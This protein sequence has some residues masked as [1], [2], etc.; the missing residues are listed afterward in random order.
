MRALS[1][2]LLPLV[3]ACGAQDGLGNTAAPAGAAANGAAPTDVPAP[4]QAVQTASL[5]GLYESGPAAR[6]SQMCII[7]RGTGNARFGLVL[8]GAGDHSCSGDGTA[9]R[10]GDRLRLT[11]SGD[12]ACVIE[13]R[14]EGGQVTLPPT[15]PASC[16]YYCGQGAR[17]AA[18][19]FEKTGGTAEDAMRAQDLVG[20]RLCGG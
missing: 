4:V 14:I 16:A 2:L 1:L 10:S 7:D 17:L 12:Q 5:T 19:T 8:W 13:A 15:A 18:V 3:A 9:V 6:R 11:M 20:D